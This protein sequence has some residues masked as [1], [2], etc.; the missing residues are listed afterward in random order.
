[1]EMR[2]VDGAVE[3]IYQHDDGGWHKALVENGTLLSDE[4]CEAPPRPGREPTDRELARTAAD[5]GL[6]V[7]E[8][9]NRDARAHDVNG[10]AH[11]V[12]RIPLPTSFAEDFSVGPD[13]Y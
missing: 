10:V 3:V 2:D 6:T 1:M 8:L 4:P 12:Y 13:I 11:I 7:E 5:T 9:R